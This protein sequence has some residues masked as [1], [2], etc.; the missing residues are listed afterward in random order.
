MP[1]KATGP[2]PQTD[3]PPATA[4]NQGPATSV[5]AATAR[6]A[7]EPPKLSRP[8]LLAAQQQ[9]LATP[10]RRAGIPARVLFTTM[11]LLYGR[12]RGGTTT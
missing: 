2:R 3:P 5:P 8:E 6:P 12:R 9:T 7:T 4:E 11:D 1:E 10:R